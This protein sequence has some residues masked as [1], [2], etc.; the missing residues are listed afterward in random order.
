M[1]K[2]SRRLKLFYHKHLTAAPKGLRHA[3]FYRTVRSFSSPR[4][5]ARSRPFDEPQM[6]SDGGALLLKAVD[7]Q[8]GLTRRLAGA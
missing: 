6:T 3:P 8:V 4:F 5:Q 1:T 7:E 2:A